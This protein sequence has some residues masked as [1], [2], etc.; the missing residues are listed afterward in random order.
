MADFT[1]YLLREVVQKQDDAIEGMPER[2]EIADG[3]TPLGTLFVQTRPPKSPKWTKL[4]DGY[5]PMAELGMVQSTGALYII[6]TSNRFF[7]LAFGQGRH[8]LKPGIA[9]DRFG[10]LVVLNS[11]RAKELRSVDKR[12][13][14][15]V[16]QNSRVQTSQNS[17]PAEFGIDIEKDLIRGITASPA[18]IT[19]GRR[20]T[21]AD[22]LNVAVDATLKTLP[23]LLTRYLALFQSTDYQ[24]NF[25]WVDNIKQ[26]SPKSTVHAELDAILVDKLND[27][28]AKDGH[29][30]GCW[31]AMP[32]II[33]WNRVCRFRF[34]GLPS[35][36][37]HSDIHLPGFMGSLKGDDIISVDLLK[38]RDVGAVDDN[39]DTV[40]KWP[41]YRCIHCEVDLNGGSYVF[42]GGHWFDV[43]QDFVKDVN[44]YFTGI[45][46]YAGTFID[47]QHDDE[48]AYNAAFCAYD[49]IRLALM[50]RKNIS[51]GG[52][53]DKAEFCD[54]YTIDR[55]LIH[56]KRY[57]G[58][59]LLGHLFNQ[60]LVSG[61]LLRDDKDFVAKV[62]LELPATH[63]LVETG[64]IPRDVA[65]Y[66]I[67]FAI[68][69]ESKDPLSIPFFARVAL[70]HAHRQL[71]NLNY[72]SVELAK[73]QVDDI[74][75]KTQK[76]ASKRKRPK[77]ATA[78]T[79]AKKVNLN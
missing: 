33:D 60:G 12:S 55:H 47:Y 54:V 72:G 7:A 18:D 34:G 26:I 65:S 23:A 16:D 76:F 41:V 56:I 19:L 32:D 44:G 5:V 36:P 40:E 59:S 20:F 4:F 71:V 61:S 73:I 24:K 77:K 37:T 46:R 79:T 6:E 28:R 21:G 25:D 11:V 48:A 69:S 9:E 53:H 57:G 38:K 1:V 35:A 67:V 27:A 8:L 10:L 13:F 31:L 42:S 62:N 78:I 30:P 68:V 29:T 52:I 45:P 58:S 14:D 22:A 75:S 66:T 2:H 70:R 3:T 43:K 50:D 74:F 39:G 51:V 63:Q 64:V 17:A 15:T 49:P